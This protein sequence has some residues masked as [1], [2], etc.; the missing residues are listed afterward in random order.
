[1]NA[2]IKVVGTRGSELL[3]RVESVDPRVAEGLKRDTDAPATSQ[4]LQQLLEEEKRRSIT[5]PYQ[6]LLYDVRAM[7]KKGNF[8]GTQGDIILQRIRSLGERDEK[9]LDLAGFCVR[10]DFAELLAAFLRTKACRL[11][12]LNVAKTQIGIDGATSLARAANSTLEGLQFSTEHPIPFASARKDARTIR[13]VVLSGKQFNH[14]DAAAIGVLIERES[15]KLERLNVSENRLT[16]PSTNIFRGVSIVF[17]ALKKGPR[18]VELNL[19]AIELRSEG[20]TALANTIVDLPVLE[21][22]VLSRNNLAC[23]SFGDKM[24]TGVE[25][26]CNQLWQAKRLRELSLAQNDLDYESAA[27]ISRMLVV[28]Q[29]LIQIDLS[30]NPISEAGAVQLANGLNRNAVLQEL[31]L[32]NCAMACEA[33][34]SLATSLRKFN[35]TLQTLRLRDNPQIRSAGYKEL[36]KCASVNPFI[37]FIDVNPAPRH[38]SFAHKLRDL[39]TVNVMLRAL[40]QDFSAFDFE[41]LSEVLRTNF[42]EKLRE[43]SE[44]ELERLYKLHV[45]EHLEISRLEGIETA[46]SSLRYY[47]QMEQYA[48]LKRL[49]WVLESGAREI[50]VEKRPKRKEESS[51]RAANQAEEDDDEEDIWDY[52]MS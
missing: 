45:L 31:D 46:V 24:L 11:T 18:L 25:T 23:N 37:L 39:L 10:D 12:E 26:F 51:Q 43:L 5:D 2:K 32:S 21:K 36:V 16:G 14:L 17:D 28:N 35:R 22:L 44:G 41:S 40:R 13:S 8:K 38:E 47:S 50:E 29:T 52:P 34:H 3:R 6:C 33:I 4:E 7:H 48:P 27:A 9:T 19:H 49:L 15:K 20:L 30:S 42:I 1:M